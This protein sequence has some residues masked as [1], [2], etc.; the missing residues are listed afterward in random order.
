MKRQGFLVA[1]FVFLGGILRLAAPAASPEARPTRGTPQKPVTKSAS[2]HPAES[3]GQKT[4]FEHALAEQ[5]ASYYGCQAPADVSLKTERERYW[6]VPK[7]ARDNVQFL[8]A[9]V[10]DPVHTHLGMLFDRTLQALQQAVQQQGDYSLDRSI[11]PWR[12]S[13]EQGPMTAADRA[14]EER[15]RAARE[16]FPGLL[17]FRGAQEKDR[18]NDDGCSSQ[19]SLFVFLVAETPTSGIRGSQFQNSL[20]IMHTIR[21]SGDNSKPQKRRP[22]YV[23]GPSFSGSLESLGRQLRTIP[24]KERPSEFFV[25]SGNVTSEPSIRS[26]RKGFDPHNPLPA[27]HFAS[28]QEND[29]FS[30]LQFA[31]FAYCKGYDS[32]EIAVLSEDDTAYGQALRHLFSEKASSPPDE[33]WL[34]AKCPDGKANREFDDH[35]SDIVQL[36]FPREISFFRSAYEK[37]QAAKQEAAAKVP[38]KAILPLNLEDEGTDDDA[39]APY[40][41]PQTSLS[42]EAVMLGVISELQKHHIKFTILLATNPLDQLFLA[43]YL[44]DSY[45]QGRVIVTVPD[46]LLVSQED[47]LLQGV[48][49]LN[50]YSLVP[51]QSDLL[52]ESAKPQTC[53]P[54]GANQAPASVSAET[55][56]KCPDDGQRKEKPAHQDRLFESATSVG[57]FNAMVG[58]LSAMQFELT[59]QALERRQFDSDPQTLPAA[60]YVEYSPPCG[61]PNNAENVDCPN[62]PL[63][64]LTILGHDGYWPIAALSDFKKRPQI[65]DLRLPIARAYSETQEPSKAPSTLLSVGQPLATDPSLDEDSREAHTT[66]AWNIAFCI[67][68]LGLILHAVLSWT[69]T[70]LSGT[71]MQAQFADTHDRFGVYVMAVGAFWLVAA[72]V[73]VLCARSPLLYDH[74]F[75]VCNQWW[76]GVHK[77]VDS[78]ARWEGG[79]WLTAVMWLVLLAFMVI[80]NWNL[81][82]HRK[83]PLAAGLFTLFSVGLIAFQLVL[84]YDKIS[85]LP[86]L[87]STRYLHLASGVSPIP[88]FLFLFAAG[89]WWVWLS[90]RALSIVDLRRPRLPSETALPAKCIRI[91]DAE[92]EKV[93]DS[94]HPVRFAWRVLIVVLGVFLISLTVLDLKHPLQSLEGY[95]YDWGYCGLLAIVIAV[96]L[97]C[98]IRLTTTWFSYKQVLTGLDRSPLREAFSRMKRLS[99]KSMWNPGGS[100]LRETYRV[101]SRTFENLEKLEVVLKEEPS[102]G[103][104][105]GSI[106]NTNTA[107]RNAMA[108]YLKIVPPSL[109]VP[110]QGLNQSPVNPSG[111]TPSAVIAPQSAQVL[112]PAVASFSVTTGGAAAA[113]APAK[114]PEPEVVPEPVQAPNAPAPP[115]ETIP[116]TAQVEAGSEEETQSELLQAL[117]QQIETL[118]IRMADTAGFLIRDV[119]TPMWQTELEP[120]VSTDRRV[121]KADLPLVRALGEE[122]AALVYVNF[123]QSILLQMRTLVICAAGMYVLIVCSISIYPFEPH[124]A[125]QVLAVVLLVVAG[126]VVGFVYAEM[127]RDAILSRLTSTNAGELGWDFWVKFI[128]AGALPVF[129]LLAVQFP[130]I[131]RFLFSWLEPLLQSA[132]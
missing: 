2:L 87:W 36:H 58:L 78:C 90:L 70:F 1:A 63:L 88:P 43:R 76:F 131:G 44:R 34:Q 114:E 129:S 31:R 16:A 40:A 62:K 85:S 97:G 96:Y 46:L 99:W 115:D 122:Y 20:A 89:Y 9:I 83:M 59:P 104:V 108:T 27:L 24:E 102:A 35:F 60:P 93:R 101:M 98:L 75:G 69:G 81:I 5:I 14:N 116:V 61:P 124:P 67:C 54:E 53:P 66:P 95:V 113:V 77:G 107:F 94:A 55:P 73:V 18:S 38:G 33:P 121:K 51:G 56:P 23:F 57:M 29:S 86:I 84:A 120:V 100:T 132:K 7:Q 49:G 126:A 47:S 8:V 125:L 118:Q 10:P 39:V 30:I 4:A 109:P 37:E 111:G 42:Q 123:L 17:I 6:N 79:V 21:S 3:P 110:T 13:V 26:F 64:W 119:L 117:V 65:P 71:E 92:G 50:V 106:T 11:L 105:R 74:W 52:Q 25:Y 15:D 48:L 112:T 72:F 19:R 45:P 68:V 12:H 130:E 128:S 22:L 32:K 41:G 127:H 82:V 91:S 28:F 80:I 103:V